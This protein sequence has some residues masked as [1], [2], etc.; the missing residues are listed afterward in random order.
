MSIFQRWIIGIVI[1]G[2]L[3]LIWG[4]R[5]KYEEVRPMRIGKYLRTNRYTSK[6]QKFEYSKGWKSNK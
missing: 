3:I 1:A 6:T 5:W 2:G 4:T